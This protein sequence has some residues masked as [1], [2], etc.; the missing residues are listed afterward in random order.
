MLGYSKT[1]PV[2]YYVQPTGITCQSTCLKMFATYLEE[3]L[4]LST[5]A[6][7]RNIGDIWTDINTGT[8]RPVQARNAHANMKWWLETHFPRVKFEYVTSHDPIAALRSIVSFIDKGFPVMMSVS[9][10]NVEGHII[11]VLGY[12][13][14]RPSQSS[15]DFNLVVHDPFGRFDPS[16][17]QRLFGKKRWDGGTSLMSGGESG[18]GASVRLP[19]ES[20]SR[21]R[22]GDARRGTFYLLSAST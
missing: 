15:P 11:L 16:L 9:H 3:R 13:N 12:E 19:L 2:P 18:P 20:V 17:S 4:Q 8:K 6:G 14:Y 5:G 21:Q 1:L 22:K 7:E 10:V